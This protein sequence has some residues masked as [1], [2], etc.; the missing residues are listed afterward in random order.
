MSTNLNVGSGG[1]V[2]SILLSFGND[3]ISAV[4]II[5]DLPAWWTCPGKGACK[6]YCSGFKPQVGKWSGVADA[7]WSNFYAS[8]S[9]DFVHEMVTRIRASGARW[10]RFHVSGDIYDQRYLEKIAEIA[11]QCPEVNFFLYTKSL[12]LNLTPL[13]SLPNVTLIKSL[14][15]KYDH[16]ILATDNQARVITDP[17]QQRRGEFLCPE[18]L[19]TLGGKTD[20]KLCGY[21]C[22]YCLSD[23]K[24]EKTEPHQI[25]VCFL[26]RRAGWNGNNVPPPPRPASVSPPG[27][28]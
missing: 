7:R 15:G 28:R 8:L 25:K 12:Q 17:Q 21:N 4:V 16:L 9:P 6:S 2:V 10:V 22:C 19:G 20:E 13:T 24:T 3:K 27:G 11:R 14:G 1:S 18:G 23:K 5:F 26:L